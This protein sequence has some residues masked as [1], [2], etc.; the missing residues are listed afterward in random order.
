MSLARI[1]AKQL[2]SDA[3]FFAI[4]VPNNNSYYAY[5]PKLPGCET[6][7]DTL[8][9]LEENIYNEVIDYVVMVYAKGGAIHSI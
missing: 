5:V 2:I 3:K 4:I 7:A 9:E 1:K 8:Q 6:S